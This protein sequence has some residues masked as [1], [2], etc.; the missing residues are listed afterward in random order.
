MTTTA[1]T[2]PPWQDTVAQ[3][4][5]RLLDSMREVAPQ[6]TEAVIKYV[7]AQGVTGLIISLALAVI[8]VTAVVVGVRMFD[9]EKKRGTDGGWAALGFCTEVVALVLF[10]VAGNFFGANLPKVLAPEGAAVMMALS[11]IGGGQ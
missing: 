10:I 8:S 2:P 6:I 7:W 1:T 9:I 4:G 11:A 3:E 5:S